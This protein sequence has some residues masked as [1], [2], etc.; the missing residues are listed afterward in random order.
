MVTDHADHLRRHLSFTNT[1]DQDLTTLSSRARGTEDSQRNLASTVL[2][3]DYYSMVDVTDLIRRSQRAQETAPLAL[4]PPPV[5]VVAI[6]SPAEPTRTNSLGDGGKAALGPASTMG[7]GHGHAYVQGSGIGPGPATFPYGPA[8]S[9]PTFGAGSGRQVSGGSVC[10]GAFAHAPN[11][12]FNSKTQEP[13]RPV[14]Q[15]L[16]CRTE[17]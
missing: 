15:H 12:F 3:E 11:T 13:T 1:I 16:V 9:R 4:A 7:L 6:P 10:S 2:T 14:H 8:V 5:A 17:T